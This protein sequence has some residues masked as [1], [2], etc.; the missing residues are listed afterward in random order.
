[1]WIL[2]FSNILFSLTLLAGEQ[3]FRVIQDKPESKFIYIFCHGF[4]GNHKHAYPYLKGYLS[5]QRFLI[6]HSLVTFDFPDADTAFQFPDM[7]QASIAQDDDIAQLQEVIT[8][9]DSNHPRRKIVLIGVS[10]GASVIINYLGKDFSRNNIAAAIVE[11]PFDK[12]ENVVRKALSYLYLHKIP[13][14]TRI[15]YWLVSKVCQRHAQEGLHPIDLVAK[16][17]QEIPVLFIAGK[18][19]R[20]IDYKDSQAL[21]RTLFFAGHTKTS[22]LLLDYGAHGD[23]LWGADGDKYQHFVQEFYTKHGLCE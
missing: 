6:P 13:K 23:L 16:I 1:M 20:L 15:V 14:T 19:D 2:F 3:F 10:R 5:N 4:G 22:F 18:E 9:V 21:Y 12:V 7:A 11:S 8:W 17:S